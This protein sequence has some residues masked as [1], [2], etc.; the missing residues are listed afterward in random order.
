MINECIGLRLHCTQDEI[1]SGQCLVET[2]EEL[3]A[4]LGWNDL[5]VGRYCGI[6]VAVSVAYRLLSWFC[7]RAKVATL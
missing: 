5:R 2:G 6:L 7:I 1:V 3:L 4:L